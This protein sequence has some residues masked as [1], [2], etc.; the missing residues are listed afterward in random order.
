MDFF[1][2]MHRKSII[3]ADDQLIIRAGIRA[4]LDTMPQYTVVAEC[5]EGGQ[6]VEAACRL[7]PEVVILDIAMPGVGGIE[8]ARRIH[9]CE[10]NIKILILSSID[11]QEVIEQA[12][13]A[14]AMGY[15]HKEF[16]LDELTR[17]LEFILRDVRY[18]SPKIQDS[19][20]QSGADRDRV[21]S[22]LLTPRQIEILRLVASGQTNKEIAI[23]LGIS[24]K[25]V[26]F[27]RA[28]MMER[29]GVR[30]VTGLTRYAMK[31]GIVDLG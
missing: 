10:P 11:R 15:L 4:L 3:F 26:E 25:T 18:L 21:V 27:H 30:D 31:K 13:N 1:K 16:I 22:S 17:A 29:L 24:P 8:A 6:A 2:N 7:R 23:S 28:Q 9:Q 12:L 14:G 20:I 5:A 19:L